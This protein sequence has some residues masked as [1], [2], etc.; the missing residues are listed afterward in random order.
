MTNDYYGISVTKIPR[1]SGWEKRLMTEI[2]RILDSVAPKELEWISE[3]EDLADHINGYI[4]DKKPLDAISAKAAKQIISDYFD[5]AYGAGFGGLLA[6]LISAKWFAKEA[7]EGT[8]W[9]CTNYVTCTEQFLGISQKKNLDPCH[10]AIP[11]E[12]FEKE[13]IRW[14][15]ILTDTKADA[16]RQS[17]LH[18]MG[19]KTIKT[20]DFAASNH[21]DL[22]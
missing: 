5:G 8:N 11:N 1:T 18:D 6:A 7:P 13:L 10:I 9:V 16:Q 2:G 22:T 14:I 3:Y 20:D 4:S 21:D 19:F 17:V 12:F 15:A